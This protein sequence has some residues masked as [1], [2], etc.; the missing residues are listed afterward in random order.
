MIGRIAERLRSIDET[1]MIPSTRLEGNKAIISLEHCSGSATRSRKAYRKILCSH[2]LTQIF[3]AIDPPSFQSIHKGNCFQPSRTMDP[4]LIFCGSY[5]SQAEESR[6]SL[7]PL[8]VYILNFSWRK[9]AGLLIVN[10]SWF[11]ELQSRCCASH[12]KKILI[13]IMV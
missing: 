12:V 2:Q 10:F 3:F 5:R 9:Q 4:L 11:G 8:I 1:M 6:H 13:T 7:R